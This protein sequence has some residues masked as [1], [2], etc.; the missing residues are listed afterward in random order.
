MVWIFLLVTGS[1]LFSIALFLLLR[2]SRPSAGIATSAKPPRA[3]RQSGKGK[4]TRRE[5]EELLANVR[6]AALTDAGRTAAI[7]R[8]WLH[9]DGNTPS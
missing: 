2:W 1:L 6:S 5:R 8:E 7:V 9:S 4:L 3:V